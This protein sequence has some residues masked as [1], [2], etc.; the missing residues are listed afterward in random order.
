[1][2]A[3]LAAELGLY[4][5]DREA[6]RLL[7]AVPAALAHALV[8]EHP[9]GRRRQQ[10]APAQAP[11]LRR[12]A[13]VV[14]QDRHAAGCGQLVDRLFDAVA[15]HHARDRVE[16]R[17]LVAGGLRRRH[18]H[19]AHALQRKPARELG[20]REL[21]LRMLSAGHRD[22]VVVE[23]AEGDRDVRRDGGAD[24]ERAGV[25]EGAVAEVLDEVLVAGERRQADPLR[26]LAAHLRHPEQVP[27]ALA[28]VERD[29]RVTSDSD[30]DELVRPRARRRVVRAAG[31]EVGDAAG[32]L[33]AARAQPRRCGGL[34]REQAEARTR[35]LRQLGAGPCH[36]PADRAR[37]VVGADDA[38]QWQQRLAGR[39][40]LAED[41]RGA[42]HAVERVAQ[43]ALEKRELVLDHEHRPG[44]AREA[45]ELLAV[46]RPGHRDRDQPD[47]ERVE[48][49]LADAHVAQRAQHDLMPHPGSGDCD[50]RPAGLEDD[51]VQ[52]RRARVLAR[53]RE[54]RRDQ[55]VLGVEVRGR[56]HHRRAEALTRVERRDLR[57]RGAEVDARAGVGDVGDDLQRGPG[58][59]VA[60]ERHRV[61]AEREDLGD[62]AGREQRDEQAAAHRL[63][64]ARDGRGLAGRVVADPRDGAAERRGAAQ[65]RVA[66]GV[67][68]AVEP[69]SLSV[70]EAGHPVVAAPGQLSQ[71]LRSADGG[72]GELLVEA[73][74]ED[75]ARVAKPP[76]R[77]RQLAVEARQRRAGVAAHERAGVDPARVV[78][79]PQVEHGPHE[80]LDA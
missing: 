61:Q 23:Q 59:G 44:S 14:D 2:N 24:R 52:A 29:H 66:D 73:G 37:G 75:D 31:A 50:P 46:E 64:R 58:A 79:A 30:A 36:Q 78:G 43:L 49:A 38:A 27:A 55:L 51:P 5:L 45:A 1:M 4:R 18:D 22:R 7:A 3:R 56:Q 76:A 60:R 17:A 80:R 53:A 47:P 41:E 33:R 67:G 12:A 20:N 74:P 15:M 54:A 21:A 62:G 42:R 19:A 9:L 25:V 57:Q 11:L 10:A 63:G 39:V 32:K 77:R 35:A 70:P 68:R 65:V 13:V 8:D 6:A 28:A 16:R 48:L 71:Q 69:G 34:E 40:L 72:G 26:S